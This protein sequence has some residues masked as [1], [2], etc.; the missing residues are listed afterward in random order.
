MAGTKL[1]LSPKPE[2][3]R[4]GE[5]GCKHLEPSTGPGEARD[6]LR[7]RSGPRRGKRIVSRGTILE[8][9]RGQN[10]EATSQRNAGKQCYWD[11]ESKRQ[12]IPKKRE[13]GKK[14]AHNLQI[15]YSLQ[16]PNLKQRIYLRKRD[17][18]RTPREGREKEFRGG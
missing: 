6:S 10:G 17:M 8:K 14:T 7:R 2:N 13:R 4:E 12:N 1:S 5:K 3:E 16:E 9:W 15:Q 18:I 11:I